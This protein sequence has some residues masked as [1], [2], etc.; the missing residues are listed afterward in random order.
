MI[1]T[2]KFEFEETENFKFNTNIGSLLHGYIMENIDV[3]F[4]EKMHISEIRPFSQSFSKNYSG[5]WIW[6]VNTLNDEAGKNIIDMLMEKDSIYL[7]HKD[8]NINIV[9]KYVHSTSFDELFEK[10]CLTENVNRYINFNLI[11]PTAFKSKGRYI[12]YPDLRMIFMS[13]IKKYDKNSEH[14]QIFDDELIEELNSSIEIVRYNLKSTYFSLEGIKIPSFW[15]SITIKANCNP[16]TVK[17]VNMLIDF[18][19]YSGV[20]IKNAL[21]MGGLIKVKK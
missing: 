7:K 2:V 5:K 11:S 21:G 20:G 3:N 6:N 8:L 9:N 18:A 12:N 17:L 4:A 19:Q 14:T 10:N 13:I 15:G 16:V 1:K